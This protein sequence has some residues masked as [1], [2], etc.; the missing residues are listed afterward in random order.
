MKRDPAIEALTS[1]ELRSDNWIS[2]A[3]ASVLILGPRRIPVSIVMRLII[4]ERFLVSLL[5]YS[6]HQLK[7]GSTVLSVVGLHTCSFH[8]IRS[9][10]VP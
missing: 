5:K 2:R 9:V 1:A 8:E 10:C 3:P 4:I 6:T 7:S